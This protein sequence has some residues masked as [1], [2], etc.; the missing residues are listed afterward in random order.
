MKTA[1][2]VRNVQKCVSTAVCLAGN[3]PSSAVSAAPVKTARIFVNPAVKHVL[4]AETFVQTVI[5]VIPAANVKNQTLRKRRKMW[6]RRLLMFTKTG[7]QTMFSMYI[8]ML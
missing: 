4:P 1:I 5:S 6:K 3:V 7:I 8:R 2:S